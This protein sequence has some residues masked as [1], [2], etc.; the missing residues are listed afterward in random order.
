MS[1]RQSE[2]AKKNSRDVSL[3]E[4]KKDKDGVERRCKL[5]MRDWRKC[6]TENRANK[7][8]ET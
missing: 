8:V 6:M 5:R 2:S 1:Y 7:P 4:A 3:N